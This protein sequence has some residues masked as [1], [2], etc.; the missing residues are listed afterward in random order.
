[1]APFSKDMCGLILPHDS[2]GSHLNSKGRTVDD[3]LELQNF[4]K[5][6]EVLA[7]VWTEHVIDNHPVDLFLF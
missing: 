1:M 2:F 3:E 6:A 5:A 7:D 4:K